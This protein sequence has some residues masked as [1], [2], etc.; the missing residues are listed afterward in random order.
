L[1]GWA[2]YGRDDGS[3]YERFL[4]GLLVQ[5]VGVDSGYSAA[6]IDRYEQTVSGGSS[7]PEVVNTVDDPHPLLPDCER[8]DG[9][10]LAELLRQERRWGSEHSAGVRVGLATIRP[11]VRASRAPGVASFSRKS[12]AS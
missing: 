11:L 10:Q 1:S 3:G 8:F 9:G 12:N 6:R 2:G 7:V 4:L 5:S